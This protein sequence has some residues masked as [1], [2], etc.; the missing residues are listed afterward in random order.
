MPES[1]FKYPVRDK[2]VSSA[3]GKTEG[4]LE[5]RDISIHISTVTRLWDWY[6][7][8]KT[9]NKDQ[10]FG[11]FFLNTLDVCK[12]LGHGMPELFYEKNNTKAYNKVLESFNI[13]YED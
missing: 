9:I 4:R 5:S 10:R 8:E 11:Q 2:G 3:S 6:S 7:G 1:L 12:L 13:V